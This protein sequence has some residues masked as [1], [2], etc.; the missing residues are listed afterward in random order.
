MVGQSL[1]MK[2]YDHQITSRGKIKNIWPPNLA[3]WRLR[4]SRT[5]LQNQKDNVI[6]K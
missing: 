5:K 1:P 3:E 4:V 2:W 6:M